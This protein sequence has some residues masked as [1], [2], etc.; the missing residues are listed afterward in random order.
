MLIFFV[1][2]LHFQPLY[3][4]NIENLGEKFESIPQISF[5]VVE[6]PF[7]ALSKWITCSKVKIVPSYVDSLYR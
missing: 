1:L 5:H 2:S 6:I 4:Y 7:Y 3:L